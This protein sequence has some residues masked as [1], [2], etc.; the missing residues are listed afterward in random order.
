MPAPFIRA[1][2]LVAFLL[3]AIGCAS[4]VTP[5]SRPATPTTAANLLATPA[6]AGAS[7]SE[8]MVC[9]N[10]AGPITTPIIFG[11]GNTLLG[12]QPDGS[13]L[14]PV[15]EVPG[16]LWAHEPAWSPDGS[17]LAFT[18]SGASSDRMLPGLRVGIICALDRA[19]GKG[20][21]LARGTA[22]TDSM[23]EAAWTPDGRT[24]LI[25][26]RQTR[27]DAQKRYTGDTIGIVAYSIETGE[28][29]A[30]VQDAINPALSPDG[31]RLAFIKLD[32]AT[33]LGQLMLGDAVGAQAQPIQRP[34]AP[35]A[36]VLAPR[37][38]PDGE[39]LVFAASD[40]A[41]T[42]DAG[43]GALRPLID[44]LLGVRVA[45]AHGL[46]ADLWVV[47]ATGGSLRKLTNQGIDDPR[48]AWSPD[49]GRLAYSVGIA[50]GVMILDVASGQE[51]RLTDQGDYGGIAWATD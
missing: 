4:T 30:L 33:G 7:A 2:V 48:A 24:L 14:A 26:L 31:Q 36:A 38:A 29:Q 16:T 1:I 46:P 13:A 11:A 15:L 41:P 45:E 34:E 25:T 35:F 8:A 22:P 27:L 21:A 47:D 32:L 50:S 42:S 39:Q 43:E 17:T 49:G 28:V 12:I 19:T 3:T 40:G 51:Q 9:P 20:R 10:A 18:L 37:W 23:E 6:P 5:S 44:R